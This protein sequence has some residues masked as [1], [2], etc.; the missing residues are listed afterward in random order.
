MTLLSS[1]PP[2]LAGQIVLPIVERVIISALQDRML[3]STSSRERN[4]HALLGD[5]GLSFF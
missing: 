3:T 4:E 5:A 1:S 2:P